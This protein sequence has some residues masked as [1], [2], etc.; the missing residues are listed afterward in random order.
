MRMERDELASAAAGFSGFFFLLASVSVLRPVRDQAGIARGVAALPGMFAATFLAVAAAALLVAW[1]AARV[2]RSRYIPLTYRIF[3][4]GLLAIWIAL[5]AGAPWAGAALF[6]WSGVCSLMAVSLY[7]GLLTDAFSRPQ[8]ARLFGLIAAGGTAG[9]LAGP[10]LVQWLARPLG[11]ANL[12]P[13]SAALLEVS[14]RYSGLLRRS[15]GCVPGVAM[16]PLTLR[17]TRAP[18]LRSKL[19][20]TLCGYVLLLTGTAT[21]L[22]VEQAR[23]VAQSSSDDGERTLLFAR[24][25]LTVNATTLALQACV[26]RPFLQLAGLRAALS[27]LPL[28]TAA[29]FLAFAQSPSLAVLALAQGLRRAAHFGIERPGREAL[30]TAL[31]R[32]QKYAPKAF[33]D[34][35]VYRGGD[36]LAAW[37]SQAL[38]ASALAPAALALCAVWLVNSLAL[39]RIGQHSKGGLR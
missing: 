37:L 32:D 29:G 13:I 23:I 9:T 16:A 20:R 11:P 8:G 6:V 2:P 39:A 38:P 22:Y 12:I 15:A 35:V 10:L 31:D 14:V 34:S 19:L 1:I 3:A 30:L 24:I 28:L 5:R 27:L 21:L 33:I 18:L 26:A 36:A 25:D 7:W 17:D 4:A